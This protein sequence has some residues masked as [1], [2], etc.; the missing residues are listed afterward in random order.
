MCFEYDANGNR[1]MSGYA[2]GT[3]NRMTNDGVYTYTYDDEGNVTK[4]SKGA[5]AETWTFGYDH[6]NQMTWLEERSTDAGAHWSTLTTISSKMVKANIAAI[7][8][9]PSA[10]ILLCSL[11]VIVCFSLI[12]CSSQPT[13]IVCQ[14]AASVHRQGWPTRRIE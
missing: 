14:Q 8:P 6:R 4:K 3:G 9:K 1:T 7:I 13:L 2:T 12:V 10:K 11:A 5:S